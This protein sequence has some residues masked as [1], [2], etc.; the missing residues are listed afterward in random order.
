MKGKYR[1]YASV[2]KM[3]ET[4]N[5]KAHLIVIVNSKGKLVESLAGPTNIGPL[6]GR[7]TQKFAKTIVKECVADNFELEV[8]LDDIELMPPEKAT[9]IL[10]KL[11][12]K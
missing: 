8:E 1:V 12:N 2:Y 10:F 5:V 6:I 4:G 7:F 11:E 3:P 9:K